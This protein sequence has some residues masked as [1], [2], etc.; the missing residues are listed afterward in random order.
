VVG[1]RSRDG[2]VG[3]N[4]WGSQDWAVG[5]RQSWDGNS[6]GDESGENEELH[7]D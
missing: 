1:G 7:G 4:S 3:N 2:S 6:R 5:K